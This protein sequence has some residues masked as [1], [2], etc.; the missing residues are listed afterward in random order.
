M[1][2]V[3]VFDSE[4]YKSGAVPTFREYTSIRPH[5]A[6]PHVSELIV[7]RDN[8]RFNSLEI[9]TE[10]YRLTFQRGTESYDYLVQLY[11][12]LRTYPIRFAILHASKVAADFRAVFDA[13]YSAQ[14]AKWDGGMQRD[15]IIP[16]SDLSD[17]MRKSTTEQ[18]KKGISTWY[19]VEAARYKKLTG[20]EAPEMVAV[21]PKKVARKRAALDNNS[22]D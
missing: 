5:L 4:D 19:K 14:W 3:P 1:G 15:S 16:I 11:R 6:Y 9:S 20:K 21:S 12:L 18:V 22:D 2:F 10:D 7:I 17:S 13:D 8:Q